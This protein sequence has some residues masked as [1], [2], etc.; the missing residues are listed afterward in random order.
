MGK[1]VLLVSLFVCVYSKPRSLVSLNE[2]NWKD[3]LNGEWMIEFYA[4][5]CPACKDLA[6]AWAAFADWSQDLDVTVAEVDVTLNPGLSGRFLV[7]ALPTIYHVKDGVFRLYSGPRDKEDFMSFIEEKK[8]TVVD[9]IP[10]WKYPDSVQMQIVAQFFKLSMSVRDAHN[11]L[12][13]KQGIPVWG[14][15]T[16]FAGA[17]LFLGCILGFIIVCLIDCVFPSGAKAVSKKDVKKDKKKSTKKDKDSG[18]EAE[19][20]IGEDSASDDKSGARQRKD[21]KSDKSA[22]NGKPASDK[23][24]K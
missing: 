1:L 10:Q 20:A 4:P 11:H 13:E 24:K 12:V 19:P 3:M 5:W 7:T 15:Y 17:T 9:A 18:D 2:E 21:I 6:K 22:V 16:I 14:S 23:K 8:W